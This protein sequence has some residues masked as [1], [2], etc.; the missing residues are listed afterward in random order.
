MGSWLAASLAEPVAR[1]KVEAAVRSQLPQT[2]VREWRAAV[3]EHLTAHPYT[4]A[5]QTALDSVGDGPEI[6]YGSTLLLTVTW[7]HWLACAQIGDGDML[8]VCADGQSFAP[9]PPGDLPVGHRTTS[10][11]QP[12]ALG[13]FRVGVRDLD[14]EEILALLLATDGYANSQVADPWQPEVGQD[15]ARLAAEHDHHWFARQLP[16]WAQSCASAD[17]SGDDTTIALLL[18]PDAMAMAV[19]AWETAARRQPAGPPESPASLRTQPAPPPPIAA[20]RAGT[21]RPSRDGPSPERPTEAGTRPGRRFPRG[22]RVVAGIATAA[23]TVAVVLAA[24]QL[25]ARRSGGQPAPKVMAS[26]ASTAPATSRDRAVPVPARRAGRTVIVQLPPEVTRSGP[27]TDALQTSHGIFLLVGDRVWRVPLPG[28]PAQ[29][30]IHTGPLD[31]PFGPLQPWSGGAI[32]LSG[33]NGRVI[34]VIDLDKLTVCVA[35]AGPSPA[36]VCGAQPVN[37]KGKIPQ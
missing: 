24:T 19:R 33:K 25:P 4:E 34:Y 7:S 12:D 15:L 22:W 27:V 28:N 32:A 36:P 26:A 30:V 5:E 18:H 11:C 2:M 35:G 1:R 16:R 37:E 17:G 9:V 10:L 23:L 8:A 13:A 6:P 20:P 3:A 21:R 14:R 29:S 31:G